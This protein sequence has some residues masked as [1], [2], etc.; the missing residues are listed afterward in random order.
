MIGLSSTGGSPAQKLYEQAVAKQTVGDV[1]EAKRLYL[2]VMA[3]DPHFV[4]ASFNLGVIA[5]GQNSLGEAAKLFMTAW[6]SS[7]AH[8]ESAVNLVY[9]LQT[10]QRTDDLTALFP[11]FAAV[12]TKLYADNDFEKALRVAELLISLD[13]TMKTPDPHWI[14]A[15]CLMSMQRIRE[16]LEQY[17]G[18][19]KV[20]PQYGLSCLGNVAAMHWQML[21]DVD[22]AT[23]AARR[24]IAQSSAGSPFETTAIELLLKTMPFHAATTLDDLTETAARHRQ[25][26]SAKHTPVKLPP[27]ADPA[28]PLRVA[29]IIDKSISSGAS[30]GLWELIRHLPDHGI[31]PTIHDISAAVSGGG[32]GG[33]SAED[34]AKAVREKKYDIAID[35]TDPG[36]TAPPG[37]FDYRVAPV[38]AAFPHRVY[39]TASQ[40]ID[41]SFA[42]SDMLAIDGAEALANWITLPGPFLAAEPAPIAPPIT[43]CPSDAAG[44]VTFGVVAPAGALG[45]AALD[46]YASI[47]AALPGSQLMIVNEFAAQ[48][49]YKERVI[50]RLERNGVKAKRINFRLG[51]MFGDFLTALN[52][53]DI[54]IDGV[55]TPSY[56]TADAA[57][58]GV[59]SVGYGAGSHPMAR[60]AIATYRALGMSD[61][62]ATDRDEMQSIA[63]ALANDPERRR[64]FR[65]NARTG[66]ATSAAYDSVGFARE[67]ATRL[68]AACVTK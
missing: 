1:A 50:A 35:A 64:R 14:R 36:V 45:F 65:A 2:E 37:L 25:I 32:L 19:A 33:L 3:I 15:N 56:L 18:V 60:R 63:V 17:N 27:I 29:V 20:W 42:T 26:A 12:A 34:A 48:D 11:K 28:G 62:V 9:T 30:R 53:V 38:Q 22:T 67:F 51:T 44:F 4:L 21:G 13:V 43:P 5:L 41:V 39:P 8:V 16:A 49:E 40:Q 66:L 59:M 55:P 7:P 54:V 6:D 10:Q 57:W 58:Q 23:Q 46:V 24:M 31:E 47:L 52:E 68:R 61:L